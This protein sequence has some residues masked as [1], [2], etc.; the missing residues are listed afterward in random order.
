[1]INRI[2][3]GLAANP[4]A[5][6]TAIALGLTARSLLAVAGGA[7]DAG[8]VATFVLAAI[9]ARRMDVMEL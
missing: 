3:V 9:A 8:S 1:V 7:K 5:V 6:D 4:L 2:R